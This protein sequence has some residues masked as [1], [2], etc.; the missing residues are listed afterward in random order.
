MVLSENGVRIATAYTRIV[1]GD[2]GDYVE[3]EFD[4]VV[5][6]NAKPPSKERRDLEAKHPH[7]IF[8]NEYRIDGVKLYSQLR[9]VGYADYNPGMCYVAVSDVIRVSVTED[10]ITI[11]RLRRHPD[12]FYAFG[13]NL[14]GR[15]KGGQA[16]IR[17]EPNAVGIPTKNFPTMSPDAFFSDDNY[18]ANKAAIIGALHYRVPLGSKLIV[19]AQIGRNLAKLP[20]KAPKTYRFLCRLLGL[21]F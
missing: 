11:T 9:Y 8:Y 15:G 21:P 19:P 12:R 6:K 4:D 13:D 2:R 1:R 17:D 14:I 3:I 18:E 7:G 10:K 20:E 5:W 16:I